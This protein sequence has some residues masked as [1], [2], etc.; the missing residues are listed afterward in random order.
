MAERDV[1]RRRGR[2][3]SLQAPVRI[4]AAGAP[5]TTAMQEETA[6][7]VS[8]A[9]LYFETEQAVP[10][11]RNDVV[12]ASVAIPE[13]KTR[14]FPFTRVSGRGRIVRVEQ[15]QPAGSS[16]RPRHGVAVEFGENVTALS[17]IPAR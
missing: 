3:I 8:L 11:S 12:I 1:E 14:E 5:S 16:Q 2:R 17:A 7:N 15:L 10:F 4:R 13:S 9:G 6:S